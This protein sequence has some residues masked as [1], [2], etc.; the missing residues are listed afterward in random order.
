MSGLNKKASDIS[1][2]L[3]SVKHIRRLSHAVST[4]KLSSTFSSSNPPIAIRSPTMHMNIDNIDVSNLNSLVE[5]D[6]SPRST[7]SNTGGRDKRLTRWRTRRGF[8]NI[9]KKRSDKSFHA[10]LSP[11]NFES[12][13]YRG[14][15]VHDVNVTDSSSDDDSCDAFAAGLKPSE[16]MSKA[17]TQQKTAQFV[18]NPQVNPQDDPQSKLPSYI[19]TKRGGI[20]KRDMMLSRCKT[21]HRSSRR[22]M[23]LMSVYEI[24]TNGD[25]VV[26]IADLRNF[27]MTEKEKLRQLL[28]LVTLSKK[29]EY[30]IFVGLPTV[31]R[32]YEKLLGLQYESRL[33]QKQQRWL[34]TEKNVEFD[35]LKISDLIDSIAAKKMHFDLPYAV[36][37]CHLLASSPKLLTLMELYAQQQV[38]QSAGSSVQYFH[39]YIRICI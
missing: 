24:L 11:V 38:S 3:K 9:E 34:Q 36:I 13:D 30:E 37:C 25:E 28:E 26:D 15:I 1:D 20:F 35:K 19:K 14:P 31:Q 5:K 39:F 10:D 22:L 17:K 33:E 12:V 21:V 29:G 4:L 18:G 2:E 6:P 32:D 8:T 23:I 16:I 7:S 27:L